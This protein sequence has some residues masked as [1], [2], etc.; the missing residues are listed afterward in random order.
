METL[1][2]IFLFVIF[3]SIAL[4]VSLILLKVLFVLIGCIFLFSFL[5]F[6]AIPI[7]AIIGTFVFIMRILII[8]VIIIGGLLMLLKIIF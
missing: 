3:I 6:I 1:I 5:P 4:K 7:A 8:P 2:G